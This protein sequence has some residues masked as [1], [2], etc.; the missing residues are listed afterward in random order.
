MFRSMCIV[1]VGRRRLWGEWVVPGPS[2]AALGSEMWSN[3]REELWV[4]EQGGGPP[5]ASRYNRR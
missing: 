5:G 2:P 4:W 3:P 1:V